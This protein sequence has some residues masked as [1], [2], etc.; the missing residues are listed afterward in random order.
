MKKIILSFIIIVFSSTQ[1]FGATNFPNYDPSQ[2]DKICK[3][4]WT[5]R[6][7]LDERM[8]KYCMTRNKE[9]YEKALMI[10]KEY[11]N[12]DWIND[13]KNY[14]LKYWTKRGNTDYRMFGYEMNKQKEGYLDVEYEFTQGNFSDAEFKKC[15]KKWYPQFNM[16]M[17]CLKKLKN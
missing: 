15:T 8:H 12:T 6:G 5:K 11:E 16:I 3:D 9:G 10:Y 14:S 2:P 7:V 4:K 13:V 17:Y 1:G